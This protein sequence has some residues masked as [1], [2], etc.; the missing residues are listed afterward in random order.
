MNE[1]LTMMS[2]FMEQE[3]DNNNDDGGND[4]A[5]WSC[6]N[7]SQTLF[8]LLYIAYAV[9]AVITWNTLVAKPIRLIAVFIHEW[10]HAIACWLT[11]G[12][13]RQI[14]VFDNE[15]GVTTFVGGCRCLI[16]PAGYVGCGLCAMIFVILSGGRGTATFA[17]IAFTVSLVLALCYSPNK[18]LVYLCLAYTVINIIVFVIEYWFYTPFLQFLIL[19][20]GVFVGIFAIADIHDDTVFREVEGSDAYACSKEVWPC[21]LPQCI[22]LQWAICAICFQLIGI[23]IAL[24][25]MSEECEDLGWF[26]C[27]DLSVDFDDFDLWERNWDF[28]GFWFRASE[29]L[30]WNREDDGWS[31][32]R[33]GNQ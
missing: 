2:R 30:P 12:S 5:A 8:I 21:C 3:D 28:E 20:Y 22:G 7:D 33:E 10:C 25:E 6:C 14:E 26:E 16:I 9:V 23:W 24:V 29:T 18:V 13:V 15:G 19:F 17:C 27:L 1:Q 4:F 11:C 31:W 32:N